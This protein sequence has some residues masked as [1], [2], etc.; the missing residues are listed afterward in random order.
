MIKIRN[1]LVGNNC[2][3]IILSPILA[4]IRLISIILFPNRNNRILFATYSI[5]FGILFFNCFQSTRNSVGPSPRLYPYRAWVSLVQQYV[6]DKFRTFSYFIH[7]TFGLDITKYCTISEILRCWIIPIMLF[8]III[9]FF[10]S[11]KIW[12]NPI[13]ACPF[14]PLPNDIVNL[15]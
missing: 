12:I 11:I 7:F 8:K 2:Q 6:H 5:F 1:K 10:I 4:D 3:N 15:K 9:N 14:M 13:I